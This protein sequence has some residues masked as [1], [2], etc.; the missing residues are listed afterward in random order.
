MTR[1]KFTFLN[2]E[3]TITIGKYDRLYLYREK[4][5]LPLFSYLWMPAFY[6]AFVEALYENGYIMY[7]SNTGL[8][9]TTEF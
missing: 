3:Y 9:A 8:K 7:N 5:R 2:D 1:I 6:D 4:S